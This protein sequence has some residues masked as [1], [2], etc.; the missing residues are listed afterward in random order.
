MPLLLS[1]CKAST[2]FKNVQTI[3][4]CLR[5]RRLM[6]NEHKYSLKAETMIHTKQDI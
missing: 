1:A 6:V 5:I 4:Y 3:K 2:V